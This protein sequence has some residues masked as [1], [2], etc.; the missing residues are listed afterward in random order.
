M[1][2]EIPPALRNDLE[3]LR[4]LEDQLQAVLLRKQQYESELRNVDRALNELNK[5]PQDSKVYRVVGTFLLL[6]TR[7]E[8]IQD[9]NQRKELLDLHIQSLVK[10]ENLLRKQISDLEAKVKQALSTSQGGQA[11]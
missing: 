11:Q 9:L 1:A 5:L 10:Q 7:D 6:T 4:Q 3:R 2:T 8:A